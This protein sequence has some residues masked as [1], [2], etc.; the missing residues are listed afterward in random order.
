MNQVELLGRI[1]AGM[2][3]TQHGLDYID[4]SCV[5]GWSVED[6]PDDPAFDDLSLD[7][8]FEA[9]VGEAVA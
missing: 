9:H 3:Y 2:G 5:C 1:L 6:V 8:L 4:G 7:E